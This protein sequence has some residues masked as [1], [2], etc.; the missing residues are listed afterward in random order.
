MPSFFVENPPARPTFAA[1]KATLNTNHL[2]F[3]CA[4]A[5]ALSHAACG[6]DPGAAGAREVAPGVRRVGTLGGAAITESSG[7]AASRRFPGVF[8][9][10]N[11]GGG[12]RQ[13]ALYAIDRHGKLLGQFPVS[14]VAL[15][16]WEDLAIDDAGHVFIADTGNNDA[17]RREL[18][19]HR[20][21]E[22]DPKAGAIALQ[23]DRSWRLRFPAAPFDCEGLFVWKEHGY[24]VSKVFN[25]ARAEIYRFPLSAT[26]RV[27]LELVARTKIESPVTGADLSADGRLLA[28][29]AKS[30]AFVHRID[31]D[32]TRAGQGKPHQTKF[33][34][35]SIEACAFV[36]E[37]LLATAESREIF[38]FTDAAFRP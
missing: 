33:R 17:R 37:G 7:L 26:E 14:G 27:T 15:T 6:A 34:H 4:A 18:A 19:V 38:L 36:P 3:L 13:Q 8:W 25:D 10:H 21:T 29:V 9:T 16:D 1:G 22:P 24:V 2:S 35:D 20:V 30:G 23:P 32:V 5:L 12:G 31:G 28:L 11:D